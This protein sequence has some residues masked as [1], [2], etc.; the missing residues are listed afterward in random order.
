MVRAD[1]RHDGSSP[2]SATTAA[3][4]CRGVT[5]V[6][7]ARRAYPGRPRDNPFAVC[8]QA[9]PINEATVVCAGTGTSVFI[10][11]SRTRMR[12]RARDRFALVDPSS[13]PPDARK[14]PIST[15]HKP[16]SLAL[17]KREVHAG[18]DKPGRHHQTDAARP[19]RR[20]RLTRLRHPQERAQHA[21]AVAR[22][23]RQQVERGQEPVG[24]RQEKTKRPAPH[25]VECCRA[26]GKHVKPSASTTLSAGPAIAILSSSTGSSGSRMMVAT[27]P[28]KN[29][30]MPPIGMPSRRAT[31]ACANSWATTLANKTN[32]RDEAENEAARSVEFR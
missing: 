31:S 25:P 30:V 9:S 22:K 14:A 7:Q 18:E 8:R 15:H 13:A 19:D 10:M 2:A 5:H 28:N 6:G 12:S 23:S 17:G 4:E 26:N 11:Q 32:E 1:W 27:P 24:Q 29:S 3:T 20:S 21:A 16:R